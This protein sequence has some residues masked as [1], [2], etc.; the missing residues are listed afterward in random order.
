VRNKKNFEGGTK[1]RVEQCENCGG[2]IGKIEQ[3]YVH[4]GHIVC[5]ACHKKLATPGN[6]PSIEVRPTVPVQTI[7]KTAKRW[8]KKTLIGLGIIIVGV[9]G[10]QE[11]PSVAALLIALGLIVCIWAKVGA[12]WHHG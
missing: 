5:P 1:M 3:A 11:S 10:A 12:W 2:T 6:N 4:K 9:I 8:K 7:E